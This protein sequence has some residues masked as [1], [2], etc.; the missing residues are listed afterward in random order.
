[1]GLDRPGDGWR[2]QALHQELLRSMCVAHQIHRQGR[3]V[4]LGGTQQQ[5]FETSVEAF[6]TKPALA[7]FDPELEN[8]SACRTCMTATVSPP[9]STHG[10]LRRAG[11]LRLLQSIFQ[12]LPYGLACSPLVR[13]SVFDHGCSQAYSSTFHLTRVSNNGMS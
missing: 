7:Y 2:V 13:L 6:S 1:L 4:C 12:A 3:E 8:T 5:A 11:L 9:A 10:C